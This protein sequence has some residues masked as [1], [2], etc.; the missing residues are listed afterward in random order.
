[1]NAPLPL[2]GEDFA[3]YRLR[4][5]LGRGGM[6]VVYEAENPRLGSTIALKVLAPELSTDDVFRARFLKE[7][8]IAA[9]LN[10][11]NVIPIYDTGPCGELL[12]IAMR[13]VAGSDLRSVLAHGGRISPGQ[14]LLLVGQTGRALDAAH[15]HGL[16]HR[17]VKPANVLIERGAEG[18]P[19]HVYLADFGITKHTLSRSG[20]T[21]TGQFV[22]TIDYIAPEQIQDKPVDGRTDIYSL[23]CVLYECLTGRVPFVKSVDA[24]V[25]WAHVEEPPRPPSSVNDELPREIDEVIARALA[26]E[27]AERYAT[28]REFLSAA[29][30][31]FRAAPS[32][33][34]E[35][36]YASG[37][38]SVLAGHEPAGADAELTISLP[39]PAL[40]GAGAGTPGPPEEDQQKA[41]PH[42]PTP[43]GQ[44][45]SLAEAGPAARS[46]PEAEKAPAEGGRGA[47]GAPPKGGQPSAGGPPPPRPPGAR[48]GLLALA[49]L[50]AALIA[51]GAIALAVSGGGSK[52]KA[53]AA[54]V[55]EPVSATLAPVPTNH[56][57]GAGE[58]MLR[59]NGRQA[60]V[61]LSADGLING[62]PHLMHIH[63]GGLGSCPPASAARDHN[64]HLALTTVDGLKYYGPPRASL[65]TTGD[66]SASSYLKFSRFPSQGNIHYQRT[67]LLPSQLAGEVRSDNA[68]MVIHGIDY[69]GNGIYDNVLSHSELL[70][71][72]PSEATAPA[73]CGPLVRA[74]HAATGGAGGGTPASGDGVYVAELAIEPEPLAWWCAP[75]SSLDVALTG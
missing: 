43:A 24:A 29:E 42:E 11:P 51:G 49:A 20:L 53:L 55:G 66:T 25:I 73:L 44:P 36:T 14:A 3:G 39:D 56:V 71:S 16:V 23:G 63:A 67:I 4:A 68:V 60:T 1:M 34:A 31:A 6:S 48:R 28:C 8:R 70:P 12:F 9:S 10:H 45:V 30:A 15:R 38:P 54:P 7:S 33:A 75:G 59:L 35:V 13:Y 40:A 69:D 64:G 17:D 74:M 58:V 61:T 52:K 37:P 62:A 22:G 47:G 65:T 5:V 26:K 27:P 2:V 21:A 57:V 46:T 19:D 32:G 18:D 72:V 41:P 50:I